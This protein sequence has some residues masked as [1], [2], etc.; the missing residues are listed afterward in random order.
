MNR[1]REHNISHAR[2][3]KTFL[4]LIQNEDF[5]LIELS[6]S[7]DEEKNKILEDIYK[8]CHKY[9]VASEVSESDKDEIFINSLKI[10][11]YWYKWRFLDDWIIDMS[12]KYLSDAISFISMKLGYIH[13]LN[14]KKNFGDNEQLII[15]QVS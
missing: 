12:I 14:L 11:E 9:R 5:G 6:F 4:D 7:N 2:N 1:S 10:T 8:S 15:I 13:Y 3:N